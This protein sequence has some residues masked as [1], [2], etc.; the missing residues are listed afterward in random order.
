MRYNSKITEAVFKGF[1]NTNI[2]KS[3]KPKKCQFVKGSERGMTGRGK[4]RKKWACG[5]GL[6]GPIGTWAEG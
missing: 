3:Y 4:R 5:A 6:Q 1:K 2:Y